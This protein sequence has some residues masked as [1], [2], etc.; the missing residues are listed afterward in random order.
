MHPC[1]SAVSIS[2][3]PVSS[4]QVS[5]PIQ[6]CDRLPSSSGLP[7]RI[8]RYCSAS[9]RAHEFLHVSN[10]GMEYVDRSAPPILTAICPIG[11]VL[12]RPLLEQLQQGSICFKH[13]DWTEDADHRL[14]RVACFSRHLLAREGPSIHP[15]KKD[16]WTKL[17]TDRED[18]GVNV[19]LSWL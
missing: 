7:H 11:R 14:Q 4:K 9:L 12:R 5:S 16:E 13:S 3:L 2:Y 8:R 15:R 19:V 18:E 6:T 1:C 17:L 10:E